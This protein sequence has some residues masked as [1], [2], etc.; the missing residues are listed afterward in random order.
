MSESAQDRIT[1]FWHMVGPDYE[2]HAGNVAAPESPEYAAWVRLYER[3]FPAA[4]ADVLDVGT[5]TGF[6]ALIAAGLGHRVTGIDLATGMLEVARRHASA[7][8]LGVRFTEGDAVAPDY[9]EGS[10]DMITNRWLLWTLREPDR[11]FANWY[12]LLRPGGLVV[13]V[14]GFWGESSEEEPESDE[15]VPEVF[16]SYYTPETRDALPVMRLTDHGAIVAALTRAGFADVEAE[17]LPPE[18]RLGDGGRPYI[19]VAR[20]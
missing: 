19:L 4:P 14:D 2:A 11:A 16:A 12:R 17:D 18:A 15:A 3:L 10:F 1:A 20:R 9:R 13:S 6:V 5:G 7:R 8:G